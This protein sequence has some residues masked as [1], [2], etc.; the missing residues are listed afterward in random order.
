MIRLVL[1]DLVAH[2]RVWLGTL[3]VTIASGFVAAIAAGRE[4][5]LADP[6]EVR[7][8]AAP[9]TPVMGRAFVGS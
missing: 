8:M 5:V 1:S 9:S 4:A 7:D 6:M 2:A 3:A